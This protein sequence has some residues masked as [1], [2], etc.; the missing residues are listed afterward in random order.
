MSILVIAEHDNSELNAVTL[1]IVTAAG[2]LSG[3]V[4]VLV[5]GQ[6]CAAV[7]DSAAGIAGVA[8]VLVAD[9]IGRAHV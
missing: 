3:D 5:A 6:G 7:A 8:K 1:N 2:K 4:H 9:Q